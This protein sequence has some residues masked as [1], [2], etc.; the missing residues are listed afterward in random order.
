MS[1]AR[2]AAVTTRGVGALL[3]ALLLVALTGPAASQAQQRGQQGDPGRYVVTTEPGQAPSAEQLRA[4]GAKDVEPLRHAPNTSVIV[5]SARAAER[6]AQLRGVHL[7]E[8]DHIL[9]VQHHRPDHCGGPAHRQPDHCH[10]DPDGEPDEPDDEPDE[11]DGPGDGDDGDTGGDGDLPWGISRIE[12]PVAWEHATGRDV[13][14]CVADTGIDKDHEALEYVA[15]ENFTTTHP[16]GRN[17]RPDAYDDGNGH[18]THVAGTVAARDL[19]AGLMGV[20]P[21]ADLLIAKVLLDDGAGST[22]QIVDGL[23]WCA[24]RGADVINMSFGMTGTNSTLAAAV[25]DLATQGV[26]L[27]AASGNAGDGSP[28]YPAAHPEV[29]AVGASDQ[30]DGIASFS[31]RGEELNA[32]GVDVRSTVPGGHGTASGT[33]MAS[34]HV[35]GVAAL[36]LEAGAAGSVDVRGILTESAEAIADGVLV[37]AATAVGSAR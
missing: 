29:I 20:A 30:D 19:G 12:A 18:G 14:V 33:S 6:I 24:D 2:P 31:N 3:A 32:P 8:Q 25:S 28:L 35:A 7:V 1:I 23:H 17:V 13:A 21:D 15:G 10:E 9:H 26:V 4:R 22:S 11:P 36:V 27:V 37:N 16:R 5:A 34:P